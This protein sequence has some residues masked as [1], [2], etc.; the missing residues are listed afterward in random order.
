M[1][2]KKLLFTVHEISNKNDCLQALFVYLSHDTCE[3]GTQKATIFSRFV[4]GVLLS[5]VRAWSL[6]LLGSL[7]PLNPQGIDL[8][9]FFTQIV[10]IY[11]AY[12][13]I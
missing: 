12:M 9:Y 6:L 13:R 7:T 4:E 11:I 8:S 5:D 10:N 1:C 3:T 2:Y